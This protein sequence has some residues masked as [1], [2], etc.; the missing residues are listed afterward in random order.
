MNKQQSFTTAV[1]A[2]IVVAAVVSGVAVKK[3]VKKTTPQVTPIVTASATPSASPSSSPLPSAKASPVVSVSASPTSSPIN[4]TISPV[5][6]VQHPSERTTEVQGT[7]TNNDTQVHRFTLTASFNDA[8]GKVV[9]S[10]TGVVNVEA[11]ATTHYAL[12][13]T[14]QVTTYKTV[15]VSAAIQ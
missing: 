8:A 5:T 13:S 12:F 1:I 9:D 6:V 3:E 14:D 11:G 10:A 4:Y 7:V 15:D 2:A